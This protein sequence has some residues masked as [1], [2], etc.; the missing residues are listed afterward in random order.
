MH[1]KPD[2]SVVLPCFN[3]NIEPVKLALDS[4][5]NQTFTNYEC[6]IID[7]SIN[8]K[9]INFLKDY[10]KYDARFQYI[11]GN[12][13][14]LS[15]ALNKGLELSQGKYIARSDDT[16]V[17]NNDRFKIQS[18]FLEDNLAI[19]VL[20]SNINYVKS[21]GIKIG[22]YGGDH[23]EITRKLK[24]KNPIAHPTVMFRAKILEDGHKYNNNFKFCEDLEFWL[25]LNRKGYK[26]HN[27]DLCLVDYDSITAKVNYK[28]WLYNIKAR[29]IN[30]FNI[31]SFISLIASPIYYLFMF[32]KKI[33]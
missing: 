14:G 18:E 5:S 11:R 31:S 9:F 15:N 17:S 22:V 13:K 32:L 23:K 8:L 26:F 3:S 29:A 4:I 12:Q 27:L 16:D 21:Q 20:G 28:N 7:D 6:L 24:Y 30:V 1:K 2:I 33:K 25:R 19:D 10:C